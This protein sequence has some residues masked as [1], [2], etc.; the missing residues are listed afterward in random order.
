MSLFVLGIDHK[1]APVE[2]REKFLIT[3]DRHGEFLSLVDGEGVLNEK[4]VL[5]TCN[6]TEIYAVASDLNDARD[7]LVRGLAA[8]TDLPEREFQER[9]YFKS[10]RDSVVHL[11]SVASGLES[12]ALG[13]TE[14]LG[15]VKDAYLAAQAFGSTGK[16]LN[17]FFQKSL[18]VGK[19]VRATTEIGT[20]K[21]SVASIA[22]DLAGNIFENF[23]SKRILV[24]GSGEVARSLCEV[25]GERG[26]ARFL[27]ANRNVDRAEELVRRFGGE[28]IPFEK[29]GEAIPSV[30]IVIASTA[31]P[32]AFIGSGEVR[33]WAKSRRGRPLFMIDLGVPRNIETIVGDV[34]DVYLYNIDDLRTIS[35]RNAGVRQKA[36]A[37]CRRI[38]EE[39]AGAFMRRLKNAGA[40]LTRLPA[41]DI[42]DSRHHG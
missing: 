2:L 1:H 38:V 24:I 32:V 7:R 37:S 41:S 5:S 10:E 13:E 26:A 22:I 33:R 29:I 11:F 9:L 14:I 18:Q 35:D 27:I 34:P 6:R 16:V 4:A 30:D 12:M 23:A 20:G 39:A 42:V 25:M 21:I 36:A 28:A 40:S 17:P 3:A 31:C 15:Q 8:Y 19:K